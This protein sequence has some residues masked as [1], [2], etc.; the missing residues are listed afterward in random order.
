MAQR[1][2][3]N[4]NTI[5]QVV[6]EGP[7]LFESLAPITAEIGQHI[8]KQSQEAKILE[9]SSAAQLELGKLSNDFQIKY[10]S[11]P[12]NE[13]GLKDFRSSRQ[14][15][16][17]KYNESISPL[18]RRDWQEN[19]A[20]L[21]G[22]NDLAV[23]AWGFK[24]TA[25][26][27]KSSIINANA[28]DMVHAGIL[29]EQLGRGEIT[30]PELILSVNASALKLQEFGNAHIG[31]VSTDA[32]IHDKIQDSIKTAISSVAKE[33]P[34]LALQYMDDKAI[35]SAVTNQEEFTKFRSAVETRALNVGKVVKQHEIL[36]VLKSENALFTSGKALSYAEIQ[37]AT[38]NM[39][40]GAK[41]YFLKAN[42]Y[43]K[44]SASITPEQKLEFK[45]S[46]YDQ[47]NQ[48]ATKQ[49]IMPGDIANMQD[50]IFQGMNKKA[51]KSTE[52]ANFIT[53]LLQPAITRQ[54]TQLRDF[55]GG[56]GIMD[57]WKEN[58]G[59]E[60]VQQYY[61]DNVEIKLPKGE[62]KLGPISHAINSANKVQ[63]YDNY[64]SALDEQAAKR[65]I[66][67]ADIPK[68]K[69]NYEV[70][71]TAQAQ[72]I[73]QLSIRTSPVLKYQPGIPIAA[74]VRLTK[75]PEEADKFDEIFGKGA[76]I[77]VIGK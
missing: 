25:A 14:G 46:L 29:G 7:S 1:D 8:I 31:A 74:V 35:K 71:K 22:Q 2:I 41:D 6:P 17:D 68:L 76:S 38:Q 75:N 67:V 20:R 48:L 9:N 11:D 23:E 13:Q 19:A 55:T 18:F 61:T 15:I 73:Q 40:E 30:L 3:T 39:S 59:L 49:N 34:V 63:L 45:A 65:G 42:G 27:V 43:S 26:N 53:T 50:V 21:T 51:L 16:L 70:Y 37:Q 44:E 33:N 47:I 72:A 60:G 36:D 28:N 12:F 58:V 66:Q 24:Q 57:F 69:D 56:S 62:T 54:E 5:T 10:E 32:I 52:G 77:R 64:Y 4:Y